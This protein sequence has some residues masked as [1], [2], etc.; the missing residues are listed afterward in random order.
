MESVDLFK[1]I[2]L[3]YMV[4]MQLFIM[5]KKKIPENKSGFTSLCTL[6]TCIYSDLASPSFWM[7]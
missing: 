5:N 7:N 6:Y 4:Y 3:V 2:F 1:N